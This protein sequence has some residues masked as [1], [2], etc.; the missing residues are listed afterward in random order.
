MRG[1]QACGHV[2]QVTVLEH[3]RGGEHERD[4]VCDPLAG[5]VRG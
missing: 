4:G 2:R 1:S 5:D 3:H